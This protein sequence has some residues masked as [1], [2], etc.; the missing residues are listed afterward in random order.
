MADLD[1]AAGVIEKAAEV[2]YADEEKHGI[3]RMNCRFV[4]LRTHTRADHLRKAQALQ[5]AGL[6]LPEG[7]VA[8]PR[9][10]VTFLLGEGAYKGIWFSDTLDPSVPSPPLYWWRKDLAAYRAMTPQGEQG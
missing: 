6:L 2:L 8:L 5:D 10:L 9:D 4:D 7:F 1:K 3:I